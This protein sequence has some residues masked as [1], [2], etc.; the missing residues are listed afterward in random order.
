MNLKKVYY[1]LLCVI[2]FS[3]CVISCGNTKKEE[4]QNVANIT[5]TKT[6]D[7]NE[8]S[9]ELSPGGLKFEVD[10]VTIAE[11]S[12]PV[13][14]SK[15]V[16]E[17]KLLKE[18]SFFPTEHQALELFYAENNAFIETLQQSYSQHRPLVLTP[19]AV[20]LLICQ[21][22]SMHINKHFKTL[23]NVIFVKDKPKELVVRNDSLEY[24][25]KHWEDLVSSF[26][27]ET[28][29]YT[30]GDFYSFFVADFSTTGK[31]EQTVYQITLLESYKKAFTYVGES[32]CGIP[33][34]TLK[35]TKQD[36]EKLYK[37]LDDLD[38]LAL[39]HWADE[40]RPIIREFI[41]V[42]DGKID[43]SFWQSIY[44]DATEYNAFYISGWFIKFFPY[45]KFKSDIPE[46]ATYDEEMGGVKV[47]EL[48]ESNP[49]L[50]GDMY[51]MSK[52]STDNFPTGLSQIEIVWNNYFKQ[53]TRKMD[54]YA[55]FFAIKQYG[56]KSLEP[57]VSWVIANKSSKKVEPLDHVYSEDLQPAKYWSPYVVDSI[58]KPAVYNAKKYK[59]QKESL[60]FIKSYLEEKL[61][62]RKEIAPMSDTKVSFV[63]LSS[64]K[65]VNVEAGNTLRLTSIIEEDLNSLPD[66]WLP[67][68]A[69]PLKAL[70]IMPTPLEDLEPMSVN[71]KIEITLF[72][73]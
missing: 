5:G 59:T 50:K 49:Y 15:R 8:K 51:L 47:E 6:T 16:I 32:G 22:T 13:Y 44:K 1:L 34:I 54:V 57:F 52:L 66:S 23:E 19:D 45:V 24:G 2:I 37:K 9:D 18:I 27:T 63:V 42:Y 40:L 65:V 71:S 28:R 29:K 12:L 26:S 62:A 41:N 60:D 73:K 70:D 14:S 21:G 7:N 36:W 43:K 69:N 30:K 35:G 72:K 31:T 53:E 20:W 58:L 25:G 56:D 55:G 38:K 3:F 46:N 11:L 39:G 68:T 33:Y 64:G 48:Y 17:S 61:S 10:D 67:A 4:G